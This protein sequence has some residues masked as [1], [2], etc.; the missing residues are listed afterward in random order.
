MFKDI[1]RQM[2]GNG[3]IYHCKPQIYYLVHTSLNHIF[4]FA[5]TYREGGILWINYDISKDTALAYH[6]YKDLNS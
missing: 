1:T 4:H 5:K 6:S 3:H 2:V